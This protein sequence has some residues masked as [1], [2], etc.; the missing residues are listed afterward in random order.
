MANKTMEDWF[1]RGGERP[2]A[3]AE[4]ECSGDLMC[5]NCGS[6]CRPTDGG[7]ECPVCGAPLAGGASTAEYYGAD[8]DDEE[9]P[10]DWDVTM[11]RTRSVRQIAHVHVKA[12]GKEEAMNLA[13]DR[14]ENEAG[15]WSWNDVGCTEEF[16]DVEAV[17]VR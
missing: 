9:V 15:S 11:A 12:Y 1:L 2:P 14:A 7:D 6:T 17:E 3:S 8:D 16:D 5:Q 10:Q 4:N 13:E